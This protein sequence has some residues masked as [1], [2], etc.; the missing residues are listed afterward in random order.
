[1]D[2]QLNKNEYCIANLDW[3]NKR[4]EDISWGAANFTSYFYLISSF[5]LALHWT[6]AI[7]TLVIITAF[8]LV[9]LLLLGNFYSLD[10]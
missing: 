7:T 1:M 5:L 8:I 4:I 6:L 3:G 2:L 10:F 9:I